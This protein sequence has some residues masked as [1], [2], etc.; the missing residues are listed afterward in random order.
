MSALQETTRQQ[1]KQQP[2]SLPTDTLSN[3][4]FLS[5]A[6]ASKLIGVSRWTIQRMIKRGQLTAVPFGR[7]H[8]LARHQIE[9]LFNQ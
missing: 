3:K 2:T 7:K 9:N 4:D 8:I 6:D 5:I 1:P